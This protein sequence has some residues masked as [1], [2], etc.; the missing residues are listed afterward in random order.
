MKVVKPDGSSIEVPDF[1]PDKILKDIEKIIDPVM[2]M[3][4]PV[5]SVVGK[6]PVIGDIVP[7]LTKFG[8][9]EFPGENEI[10]MKDV[11]ALVPNPPDFPPSLMQKA[12]R[13]LQLVQQFLMMLPI[14][15]IDVIFK[16]L[17]AIYDMFD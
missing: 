10:S 1:D 16:M 14:I 9:Q 2:N 6:I 4:S 5:E 8:T 12:K 3:M 11:R 17:T 13:L 7:V 15:L